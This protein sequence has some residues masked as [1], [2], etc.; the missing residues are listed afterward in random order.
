[1]STEPAQKAKPHTKLLS[2][3]CVAGPSFHPRFAF[4]TARL[5]V[6][7]YCRRF[8]KDEESWGR[9]LIDA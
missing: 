4:G 9:A 7:E 2:V 6:S 1:M 3:T 8:A 5:R